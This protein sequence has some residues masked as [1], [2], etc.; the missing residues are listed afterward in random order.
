MKTSFW[1]LIALL[2]AVPAGMYL[3][4]RWRHKRAQSTGVVVYATVVS[5]EA[6]KVFGKPSELMKIRLWLQEPDK[7]RREVILR[8]RMA[9]G[10]EIEP[11][12]RVAVVVDPTNPKK[13]YPAD[14]QAQKRV[15]L[16]GSR[17]ERRQMK[18]GR[19]VQRRGPR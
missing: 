9:P 19:G 5:I 17:Q 6:D 2:I 12:M 7:D 16:T 3:F 11:G 10:Q 1:V 14:E 8:S 18:S 13:V 4:Q 15:V